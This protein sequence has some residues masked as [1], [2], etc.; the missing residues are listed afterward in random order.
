MVYP[1]VSLICP[2]ENY[3]Q[4]VFVVLFKSLQFYGTKIFYATILLSIPTSQR[5][6]KYYNILDQTNLFSYIIEVNIG[7]SNKNKNIY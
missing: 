7:L 2:T 4:N 3:S 1:I 6:V 5:S